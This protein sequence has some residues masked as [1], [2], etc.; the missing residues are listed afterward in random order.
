MTTEAEL[1]IDEQM[2]LRAPYRVWLRSYRVYALACVVCNVAS[3]S[4][5]L[6]LALRFAAPA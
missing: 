2:G 6:S 4:S 1:R 5:F 3:F